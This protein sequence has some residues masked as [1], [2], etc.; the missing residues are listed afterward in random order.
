[1]FASGHAEDDHGVAGRATAP[2]DAPTPLRRL[3]NYPADIVRHILASEDRDCFLENVRSGINLR[4]M[5][6][7]LGSE[8]VVLQWLGIAL[9]AEGVI[10]DASSW[11][12]WYSANDKN[13][14]ARKVLSGC[15]CG[16]GPAHI[17]R[18]I[19]SRHPSHVL[20]ALDHVQWPSGGHKRKRADIGGHS[21]SDVCSAALEFGTEGSSSAANARLSETL[22]AIYATSEILNGH[23]AYSAHDR[24]FCVIHNSE[25]PVVPQDRACGLTM[26]TGGMTCTDFSTIGAR[27]GFS[28]ASTK[29]N[30]SFRGTFGADDI[31]V[32]VIECAPTWDHTMFAAGVS[33]THDVVHC[34]PQ[35]CPSRFGWPCRRVR[36]YGLVVRRGLRVTKSWADFSSPFERPPQMSMHDFFADTA[37]EVERHKIEAIK[38]VGGHLLPGEHAEYEAH[39]LTGTQQ[40]YLRGFREANTAR[41]AA[42]RAKGVSIP[43]GSEHVMCDLDHNPDERLRLSTDGLLLSLLTHG[44]MWSDQARR[45]LTRR[46]LM[47]VQGWPSIPSAH[48]SAYPLPWEGLVGDLRMESWARLVG[49]S[50]HMHV[51]ML[52][53]CWALACIE[54]CEP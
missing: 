41:L 44:C 51:L 19:M 36:Y 3:M 43:R 47:S 10:S 31:D 50:M 1:M 54:P 33:A 23:D 39:G 25:C 13:P 52:T 30:L 46:E 17:F 18:D 40:L 45:P 12:E 37:D 4:T 27:A 26:V 24:A 48:G 9:Q 5:Y 20:Q 8:A 32:G 42:M 34:S 7:G 49:N 22:D 29:P 2:A 16:R 28:G 14:T 21:D 35:P 15:S 38:R 11:F 6:S 53:M